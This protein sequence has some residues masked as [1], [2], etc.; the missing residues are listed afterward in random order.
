MRTS[1]RPT[2]SICCSPPDSRPGAAIRE[3]TERREVVVG[4]VGVEALPA[5]AEPEVL[6]HGQA[7]EDAATLGH[8]GDAEPGDARCAR[9]L[10]SRRRRP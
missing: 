7:V 3:L 2:A 10:A 6:G 1:A 5:V 4:D 8:V 9:M